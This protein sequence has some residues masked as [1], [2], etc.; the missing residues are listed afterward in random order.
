MACASFHVGFI[1]AI[2]VLCN[3]DGCLT[4]TGEGPEHVVAWDSAHLTKAGSRL[5][6]DEIYA[7]VLPTLTGA[8][9]HPND[10]A[11]TR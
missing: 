10:I 11:E 3:A 5:L 8:A 7:K 2:E 6:A 1:S 4:R 9:R